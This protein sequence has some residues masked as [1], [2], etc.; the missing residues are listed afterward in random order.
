MPIRES[1]YRCLVALSM[2]MAAG[3]AQA[4]VLLPQNI[5]KL[6]VQA[7]V[8]FV[9]VCTSQTAAINERGIP[10]RAYTFEIIEGVK[11]NLKAGSRIQVRH[12]GNDVPDARG[13]AL[14]VAGV[15]RYRVGQE[16]LLFL[17]PPSSLGL[18]A[19]VGFSQGVFDIARGADGKREIRLDPLRRKLLSGGLATAKYA[20]SRRFTLKDQDL[21]NDPP[22]RVELESFCSLVRKIQQER[23]QAEKGR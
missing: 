13:L 21:L 6:E 20:A 18:T 15:P 11:G 5:E 7:Q 19:P 22:E 23:E 9:G 4:T 1:A 8:V 12:L 2:A 17:N 3:S 16:V 14:R 10:V